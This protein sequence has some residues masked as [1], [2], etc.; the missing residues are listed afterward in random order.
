MVDFQKDNDDRTTGDGSFDL[1]DTLGRV[2]D[3]PPH[4]R[5][6]FSE[7]LTFVQ[8]YFGKVSKG[9]LI[10]RCDILDNVYTMPHPIAHYSPPRGSSDNT[11]LGYLMQDAWHVVDSVTPGV[12]NQKNYDSYIIFHAGAGRDID[13]TSLFGYDPT[14]LDIPSVYINLASLQKMFGSSYMGVSVNGGN[15]LITNS[16]VIPETES[17]ILPGVSG[18][19]LYPLGINGLLCAS[20]GSHL[21]LPDLFDTKTGASGIGRFGL[22]DGQS[23]FS[24]SGLFPPEPSAWE[25]IY[26]GWIHPITVTDTSAVVDLPAVGLN[27]NPDSVY[28]VLISE[29]EYFLVE[30]RNRD[31]NRD[32]ATVTMM[33]HDSVFTQ[34][35]YR[36]TVGF[37]AYNIS[38]LFGVITDVDE[39]DW[40]LPGGVNTDTKEWFDGGILIW[41]IDENIIDSTIAD[42]AVNANPDRKGVNLM[43]ADGSQDIGQT[44]DLLS[45]GYLTES[46]IPLDFWY[47]G[48]QARLRVRSNA[49]TPASEPGSES[50]DHANS[51]VYIDQ[52]SPRGPHMTARIRI[53]DN[54]VSPIPGFPVAVAHGVD[55][56]PLKIA[57]LSGSG[58]GDLILATGP[59]KIHSGWVYGWRSDGQAL[60]SLFRSPA[61]ILDVAL[62]LRDVTGG[63]LIDPSFSSAHAGQDMTPP[64]ILDSIC[65]LGIG[66]SV[67]VV[68]VSGFQV[69]A[70]LNVASL[71]LSLYSKSGEFVSCGRDS[72][73]RLL[74]QTEVLNS[75]KIGHPLAFAPVVASLSIA[76]GKRIVFG[77]SDGYVFSLSG[78]L[79][80]AEG[81]PYHT[82]G[83]I[84]NAPALADLL[85]DGHFDIIVCSDN[86]IY[87]LNPN[88]VPLDHFPITTPSSQPLLAAPIV[89]DVNGDG[90]PDIV[91]VTQE[92]LVL[93]YDRTGKMLNG[94]PL[95]AGFNHGSTPVVLYLP[96]ICLSCTDIGLAV[97]SDDGHVYAWRTGTLR[98]GLA[99][100]PAQPWPQVGLDALNSSYLDTT[101][102]THA[103]YSGFFPGDRA[104]NWPNPVDRSH[105]F[106]THI[107]YFVSTNATVE[108]KV[109]DLAGDLVAEF[110]GPGQGGLDNEVE[111]DVSHIQSGV[112][113][114]HI[115]AQG[116]GGHGSA[117]IKIAVVK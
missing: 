9:K 109:F 113:F 98:T 111:W 52:F 4:N 43:E 79:S 22:M 12:I 116:S 80:T 57:D 72:S 29:K 41:H 54:A 94:F 40:S 1:S 59:G 14:P 117:V 27:G 75:A 105:G 114:A 91:T 84:S 100:A 38:S 93:A 107:R 85:G 60:D 35:W 13:L 74:T 115:D 28:R 34:T 21:G 70:A 99:S 32:G 68:G 31:A 55:G 36:D 16:M 71:G 63:G 48:N 51:H 73:V 10:V 49:F 17:R 11:E 23:I 42:D 6:Y 97:A 64:V 92:G 101:I 50:I 103:I 66:D 18:N 7:H 89:A 76:T 2:P 58:S 65:L 26:L 37:N 8:N 47:Y 82:G 86:K 83:E 87:A 81:F 78:D 56:N 104:Y 19:F 61:P 5:S 30:N 15:T 24:W 90:L 39:F 67:Y 106:K 46:G 62:A 3:A 20:V 44:Y 88:G 95:L 33:I 108:I 45:P 53:G 69:G 25:K 102:S 110:A 96:S 112:Y 77:T